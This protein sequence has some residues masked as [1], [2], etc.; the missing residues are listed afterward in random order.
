MEAF[1]DVVRIEPSGYCNLRCLHCPTGDKPNGRGTL[2]LL[3][4]ARILQHMPI[5]PR[6]LVAYH[7]GEPLINKRLP[8]MLYHAKAY[9][10][11]KTVMNTNGL[12]LS[13]RMTHNL[14]RVLDEM[15]V[16][17][18]GSSL[19]ECETIRYGCDAALV[20]SN[21]KRVLAETSIKVVIYNVRQGGGDEPPEWLVNIFGDAVEY[22]TARMRIWAAQDTPPLCKHEPQEPDYCSNLFETF[23]VMANGLVPLCCEDITGAQTFGNVHEEKPLTIWERMQSVRDAFRRKEYT[24]LCRNCWKVAGRYA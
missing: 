3:D 5:V 15:R 10:V 24:G 12:L 17:L 2:P 1:P 22:R 16:S 20:I 14:D 13:E 4:F 21:V 18:D 7:G 11:Q 19:E 23:T 6:V 9:G 8:Q